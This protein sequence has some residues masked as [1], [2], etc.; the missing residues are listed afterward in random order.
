MNFSC[1]HLLSC[2]G[3]GVLLPSTEASVGPIVQP[4]SNHKITKSPSVVL[5]CGTHLGLL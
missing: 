5:T 4:Q 1:P 3:V 2:S